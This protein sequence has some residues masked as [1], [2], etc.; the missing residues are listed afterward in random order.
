MMPS[1]P[2]EEKEKRRAANKLKEKQRLAIVEASLPENE[3]LLAVDRDWDAPY[4]AQVSLTPQRK[5]D[6]VRGWFIDFVTDESLA[7]LGMQCSPEEAEKYFLTLPQAKFVITKLLRI[8]LKY[9]AKSRTGRI[10][11]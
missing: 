3:K 4:L 8:F 7:T 10:P 5:Y 2:A 1:M 11:R 6:I 9:L